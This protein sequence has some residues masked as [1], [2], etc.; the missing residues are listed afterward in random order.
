[1]FNFQLRP[2]VRKE[3]KNPDLFIKGQE[4][5]YWGIILAMSSVIIMLILMFKDPEKVL[6]PVWLMF[7]GLGLAG[8]GEVQKFRA[9]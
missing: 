9:K 1:M 5:L 4:K 3:L 7:L 2:E 8:W 6:H